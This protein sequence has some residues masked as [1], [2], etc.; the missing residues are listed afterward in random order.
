MSLMSPKKLT[1]KEQNTIWGLVNH[2][3]LNDKALAKKTRLKL[4]TVTAIRRRLREKEYYWTVNIPNFYHLGYELLSVEYGPFNEAVPVETRIEYFKEFA[5]K[6]P[7]CVFSLMSRSNG[8]VFN[9]SRN[10]AEANTQFEDLELFFTHHHLT[11][12]A[13]WKRVIFPFQ[14]AIFWNFFDFSPVIRYVYDIK[15]KIKLQEYVSNKEPKIMRLSKKEKKVIY[16]LVKYPEESDNNIADRFGVSRQAV[17]NIKRKLIREDLLST[18]RIINFTHS[19]CSLITFTYTF[20]GTRAPINIRKGGLEYTK[21]NVPSFIG[22]SSNFENVMFAAIR[23]YPEFDKLRERML[24]FYKI[25]MSIARQPEVLLFP[26]EDICYIKTPTFF[27]LLE[28]MLDMK[29]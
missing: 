23:N 17:S 5:E 28:E 18:R 20:F 16:G 11:D 3:N 26:I 21:S 27:G 29:D 8:L 12:E 2:P 4:S 7:N 24:S 6:S 22:I 1:K 14:T 10:Y 19:G 9:I 13:G 25:H 15:R